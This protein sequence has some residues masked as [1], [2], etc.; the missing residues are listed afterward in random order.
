MEFEGAKGFT[1]YFEVNAIFRAAAPDDMTHATAELGSRE[2]FPHLAPRVYLNHAAISP[3]SQPAQDAV[4]S[5]VDTIAQKGLDAFP[6]ANEAREAARVAMAGLLRANPKDIALV[7]NTTAGVRAV[8]F[9][10]DWRPR[11]RVITFDGEFPANVTP[12]AQAAKTFDLEHVQ[13]PLSPV[14][15]STPLDRTWCEQLL[16]R[17]RKAVDVGCRL[18]AVSAVQ[19]D[20]GV[21]M[22][23]DALADIAHS[24]GALLFVDGIQGC[25]VVPMHVT[26]SGADFIACGGHKWLMGLEGAGFLWAAPHAAAKLVPRM[27]GWMSDEEP[28]DFLTGEQPQLRYDKPARRTIDHL[29][30][31][32]SNALGYAAAAASIPLITSIGVAGIFDHVQAWHDALAPTLTALGFQSH[33]SPE[34]SLRSGSLTALPPHGVSLGHVAETLKTAGIGVSTPNGRIRFA[35][36]WP[37]ALDEVAL[38]AAVLEQACR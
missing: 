19:F 11:D 9:G 38:V 31:A 13:I 27:A 35:P 3:L 25:G 32:A 16:A 12:W 37:N 7:P 4:H 28:F 8:A 33:R 10:L 34:P 15:P 29:E 6:V 2:L 22:P 30:G 26:T 21:A 23:I 17:T 14:G 20:T 24:A 18:I 5:L 36:H 1:F